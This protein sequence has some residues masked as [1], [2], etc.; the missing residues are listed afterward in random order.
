MIL[1]HIC[2]VPFVMSGHM[3][4]DLGIRTWARLEAIILLTTGNEH[5]GSLD[6]ISGNAEK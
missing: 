1:K 5:D 6:D 4:T 2:K 3:C